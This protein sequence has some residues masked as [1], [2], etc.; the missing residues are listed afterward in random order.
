MFRGLEDLGCTFEG[1]DAGERRLY[2]ID[3]PPEADIEAIY[4]LLESAEDR[5]E[6]EFEEAHFFKG[7]E[8]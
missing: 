7:H 5:G 1:S 2:S 6:W 3:V 4:R 8:A